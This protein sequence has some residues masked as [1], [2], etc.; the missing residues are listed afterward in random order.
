[1]AERPTAVLAMAPRLTEGMFTAAHRERLA[2][3][4]AV[5][6]PAPLPGF[7]DPRAGGLLADAEILV[8]GWGCPPLDDAVLARAPACAW[9]PTRRAP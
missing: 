5:P 8:T 7:D 9:W 1:M 6:D 2:R 3:L 4:C